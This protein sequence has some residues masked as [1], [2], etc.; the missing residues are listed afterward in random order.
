MV[1]K[2][3]W[4]EK[5]GGWDDEGSADDEGCGFG[6]CRPGFLQRFSGIIVFS[7]FMGGAALYTE[8]MFAYLVSQFIWLERLYDLTPGQLA[9]LL[10]WG[11]IGFL[12][13]V[14]F[15]SVFARKWHMPRTLSITT[16]VVAVAAILCVLPY[17]IHKPDLYSPP[18]V[19]KETQFTLKSLLKK[20]PTCTT[21]EKM[22]GAFQKVLYPNPPLDE[23][24]NPIVA[25]TKQPAAAKPD[26]ARSQDAPEETNDDRRVVTAKADPGVNDTET[27]GIP[28]PGE[29]EGNVELPV[30]GP[31]MMVPNFAMIKEKSPL[32][33]SLVGMAKNSFQLDLEKIAQMTKEE[34]VQ[35][36]KNMPPDMAKNLPM[37]KGMLGENAD[38]FFFSVPVPETA[39][40]RRRRQAET[41]E[42]ATEPPAA[43]TDTTPTMA[44]TPTPAAEGNVVVATE[45]AVEEPSEKEKMRGKLEGDMMWNGMSSVLFRP[46]GS[47]YAKMMDP[48]TQKSIRKLVD[49]L[50]PYNTGPLLED[51][52]GAA[53]VFV[54]L[55]SLGMLIAGFAK[56]AHPAFTA[57]YIDSRSEEMKTSLY[58]GIVFGHAALG[59]V[60]AQ[61]LGFWGSTTYITHEDVG[62]MSFL[63]PRW[64]G[65]WWV[66]FIVVIV[67]CILHSVILFFY[68]N[69]NDRHIKVAKE[70]GVSK[71][72]K[73]LFKSGMRLLGN[74]IFLLITL[75][76]ALTVMGCEGMLQY[77]PKYVETQ[78]FFSPMGEGIFLGIVIALLMTIGVFGG[79]II[80]SVAK[81]S[82]F[83]CLKLVVACALAVFVFQAS[84]MGLGCEQP[85]F[86]RGDMKVNAS[87][88]VGQMEE[89]MCSQTCVCMDLVPMP[90]CGSDGV[91][92][93]TPCHAGCG[94]P[95]DEGDSFA[96]HF[97]KCIDDDVQT[98]KPGICEQDCQ[99]GMFIGFSLLLALACFI[100][101]IKA[102]PAFL[103][104]YRSVEKQDAPL[105]IG[106]NAFFVCLIGALPSSMIYEKVFD[107]ICEVG[108]PAC[109]PV[110]TCA[111]YDVEA[112]RMRFH[113]V[114]AGIRAAAALIYV[115]AMVLG[116]RSNSVYNRAVHEDNRRK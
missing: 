65:A 29:D 45:P 105:A 14:P 95:L 43:D 33:P 58:L 16:F 11:K 1:P 2:A 107:G 34:Q 15:I 41:V 61:F 42:A 55:V 5:S 84:L 92:Y 50:C 102:V 88:A 70:K 6:S 26:A 24:C 28:L 40:S 82:P 83:N 46:G 7:I 66:G 23:N 18:N 93:L 86:N 38:D 27:T 30:P 51:R 106:V 25:T 69:A 53:K 39:S 68:P 36:M 115:I 98:A 44:T 81:L 89:V 90:A 56:S 31:T 22:M 13:L 112:L 60:I 100:I 111:L 48:C 99:G 17:A 37:L 104:M 35:A 94:H 114:G 67:G 87:N 54:A 19:T 57:I 64:I 108:R 62:L 9:M 20:A 80:A 101:A 12:V 76:N 116:F 75:A 103:A 113:G 49:T 71:T 59:T 63:N 109:G 21:N 10:T 85:A 91:T 47:L 79:G 8:I 3:G 52:E 97:C 78:F 32:W 77:L 110:D 74:P 73:G 72:F 96:W 4:G